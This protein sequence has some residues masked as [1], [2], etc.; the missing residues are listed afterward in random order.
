MDNQLINSIQELQNREKQLHNKFHTNTPELKKQ[1]LE[2]MVELTRLRVELFNSLKSNYSRDVAESKDELKDQLATLHIVENELNQS[3]KELRELNQQY[4]DKMRMVEIST[5][6]SEKYKGYNGLF[7][8]IFMWMIPLSIIAFI[9]IRNPVSEQYISKDNSNTVFLVIFLLV[10][11]VALYQVL[12]LAYD[13][14]IRNN[15]NF[16]EYNFGAS[17]DY[18]Q[19]VNKDYQPGVDDG[20]GVVAHD[21]AEFE[22]LAENLNLGCVNSYCCSDGTIYDKMKKQCVPNIKT[23]LANSKQATLTKG[24]MSQ[25]KDVVNNVVGSDI[26][27]FSNNIVP[28]SSV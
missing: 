4:V 3:Q 8:L 19:A 27:S 28:F 12:T 7:K 1:S 10:F 15:M 2:E 23:H 24:V 13:L 21:T 25:A 16:N 11:F 6:F 14:S 17:F 22:K 26:E 18:D 5:Y 20:Q 9:A